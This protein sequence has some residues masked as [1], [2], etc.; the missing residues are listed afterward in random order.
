M[1][2]SLCKQ[3][4]IDLRAKRQ[5]DTCDLVHMKTQIV[6]W[7]EDIAANTS[8]GLSGLGILSA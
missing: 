2:Q 1:R 8:D 3:G 6:D 5:G 7:I 4:L